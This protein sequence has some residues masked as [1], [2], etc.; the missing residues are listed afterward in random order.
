MKDSKAVQ[1]PDMEQTP[2]M[3][4]SEPPKAMKTVNGE[5]MWNMNQMKCPPRL[6]YKCVD[7][8]G[9]T[10]LAEGEDYPWMET[11]WQQLPK[12]TDGG[13]AWMKSCPTTPWEVPADPMPLDMGSF[14]GY[15]NKF[16]F[17]PVDDNKY[18]ETKAK[19]T[20]NNE[21]D[22]YAGWSD[23]AKIGCIGGFAVFGLAIMIVAC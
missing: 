3:D 13:V 16:T 2:V 10:D 21:S 23:A 18:D 22:G 20:F 1:V 11:N 15:S 19:M 7:T 17:A 9:C 8:E 12:A 4:D 14:K 6:S 5:P